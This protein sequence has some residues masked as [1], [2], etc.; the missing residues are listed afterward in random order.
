MRLLSIRLVFD[1]IAENG[2]NWNLKHLYVRILIQQSGRWTI[3]AFI[4]WNCIRYWF[5]K[6]AVNFNW[7]L[8]I[9]TFFYLNDILLYNNFRYNN[10]VQVID[11]TLSNAPVLTD[12]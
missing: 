6:T 2:Q 10:R 11:L 5:T 1:S 3:Q 4:N 12:H 8:F 7:K 9:H